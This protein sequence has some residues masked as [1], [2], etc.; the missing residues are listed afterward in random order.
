MKRISFQN[1]K[2]LKHVGKLANIKVS[3]SCNFYAIYMRDF[4]FESVESAL[5]FIR[6]D[7]RSLAA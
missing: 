1:A 3:F 7:S 2:Y 5:R 4:V 6:E